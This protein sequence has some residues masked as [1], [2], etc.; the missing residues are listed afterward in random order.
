MLTLFSKGQVDAVHVYGW[1]FEVLAGL[2]VVVEM[3]KDGRKV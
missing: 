1:D 3:V 2:V